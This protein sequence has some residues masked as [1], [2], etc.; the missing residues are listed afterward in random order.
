M[1]DT[2]KIFKKE[3]KVAAKGGNVKRKR[4]EEVKGLAV[5]PNK[6]RS[7]NGNNGVFKQKTSSSCPMLKKGY[8]RSL[9]ASAKSSPTME[10]ERHFK[11]AADKLSKLSPITNTRIGLNAQE[12]IEKVKRKRLDS[13]CTKSANPKG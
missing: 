13:W 8:K 7:Q 2:V 9:I 5:K 4:S 12:N 10:K 3:K 1:D 11:P 6:S